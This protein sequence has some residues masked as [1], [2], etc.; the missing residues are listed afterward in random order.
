M[1]GKSLHRT[2]KLTLTALFV[3]LI[4]AGAFLKIPFVPVAFSLQTLFVMAAGL[5][6]GAAWGCAAVTVYILLGLAG[7]PVFSA[8]G[9]IGYVATPNFG[10][11]LGMYPLVLIPACFRR[12]RALWAGIGCYVGAVICL[13]IGTLYAWCYYVLQGAVPDALFAGFFLYF[14]V[15]ELVKAVLAALLFGA[16]RRPL[17]KYLD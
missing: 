16:A 8:G 11:L 10:Y 3:C 1:E 15:P 17:A 12:G 2:R 9:G 7:L 13:G 6:L 4:I 14:L 5:Y